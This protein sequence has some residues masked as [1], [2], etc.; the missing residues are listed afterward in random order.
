MAAANVW[1]M[2]VAGLCVVLLILVLFLYIQ[3]GKLKKKYEFFMKDGSGQS[4]ERRLAGEVKELRELSQT[5]GD[6]I[7]GQKKICQ[8]QDQCIQKIGF[9]K[10]NAFD[11]IGSNLSFSL[12]V[13]DGRNNGYC[14]SSVYGRNESRIFAKPII[15]GKCAYSLSMEELESLESALSDRSNEEILKTVRNA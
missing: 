13:L 14:L 1:M 8:T 12:T 15:Q 7:D 2:A 4:I 3:L 11:N 6:I 5:M 9:V 10:Y